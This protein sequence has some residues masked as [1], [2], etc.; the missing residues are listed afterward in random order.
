MT[1][2]LKDVLTGEIYQEWENPANHWTTEEWGE[3]IKTIEKLLAEKRQQLALSPQLKSKP[4]Q[5]TLDF[6]NDKNVKMTDFTLGEQI[7][8]LQKK[9]DEMKAL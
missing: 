6:Y 3:K 7:D 9:L 2:Y 1:T 8:R 5:E 4:D